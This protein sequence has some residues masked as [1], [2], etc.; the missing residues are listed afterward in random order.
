M[1]PEAIK[2]AVSFPTML[3]VFIVGLVFYEGRGFAVDPDVWW[4]IRNGQNILATHQLPT[5]DPY[6][7]TVNGTPWLSY[8]WLGDVALGF[9]GKFGLQTLDLL[10]IVLASTIMLAVYYLAALRSGNSKASFVSALFLSIF[11]FGNFSLRPQMFGFLL[12]VICLI[13]LER[14]RQGSSRALWF[15]P[16]LFLLWINMH[17]SWVIGLGVIVVTIVCGLF[18]FNLGAVEGVRWTQKQ[19]IQLEFALLASIAMIPF[20]PYGTQLAAYPFTV[21]SSLPLNVANIR[22]WL[23]MPFNLAAGKLFLALILGVFV[24]Q[25]FYHFTFRFHEWLLALGGTVMACLHARFVLLFV[26]FFAPLLATM[27]ARWVP[28]YDRAKDKF[29]FN[30][31]LIGGLAAAMIWYFPSRADLDEKVERAFPARAVSYLHS[32]PLQGPLFNSYDY[33][34]YLIAYLPEQKVFI[35]GRGDLYEIAGAFADYFQ[36]ADL[37]PAAFSILKSYGIKTCVLNRAEPLAV[38]LVNHPDWKRVYS[39]DVSVILVRK[40]SLDGT[41]ASLE[42]RSKH[43]PPAD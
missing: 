41:A 22:E 16:P 15:L 36:V 31:V 42:A 11:A 33:G 30:A 3:G 39:D 1:L 8:E 5:V 13:L 17:G 10:L 24:L 19:R 27:L 34:G 6:S 12:L 43:E 38:V 21:A 32:H 40:D 18:K 37:K 20:T 9:V 26:P 7:F 14:L 35:D 2:R 29:A 23:P 28:P 25:V 4:H